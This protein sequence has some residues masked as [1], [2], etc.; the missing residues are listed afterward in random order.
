[1]LN[2]VKGFI[3]ERQNLS[4]NKCGTTPMLIMEKFN[5]NSLEIKDLLNQ[6]YIEKFI[7]IRQGVNGQ[8][9]FLKK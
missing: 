8:L 3:T 2:Q 5:L 4:E 7:T 6:L 9:I 1:M